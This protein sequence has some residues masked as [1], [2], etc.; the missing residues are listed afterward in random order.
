M[1]FDP[2]ASTSTAKTLAEWA[3]LLD[4]NGKI[5]TIAEMM[6][7][8]N[9]ILD[10]AIWVEGNLPTGHRTTIRTDI[11]A[12]TWRKLNYGVQ[13]TKSLTA[14]VTDTIGMLEAYSEVDKELAD[15]NGN[16]SE[17]RL[18]E[19]RPHIEGMNQALATALFY[20]DTA[21]NP[22]RFLGLAPRY[23][24]LTLGASL[25]GV[26]HLNGGTTGQYN[27]IGAGGSG[28]DTT[29]AYL[30]VW[31]QNTVHMIFPK[32]SQAGLQHRDMGEVTLFDAAGG[33]YQGYRSHYQMKAGLC[34][35]DWR[36]IVRIANIETAGTSNILTVEQMIRAVNQIPTLGM[37]KPVFYV[38]RTLKTQLDIMA[39][40][41]IANSVVRVGIDEQFGKPVTSVL[42][43][44]VKVC[45]SLINTETAVA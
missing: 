32:G 44:P 39:V 6:N 43:I 30:V 9:P 27:V 36:Y 11:P 19:D 35:R 20:G 31:G 15:L 14:Q 16:T 17:F 42:G 8:T 12:P 45:D 40:A 34:V 25:P 5:A 7:Q 13:P 22:E 10:D 18:S 41:K 2:S 26:T 38:N 24:S 4:P 29:S 37:G 21:L 1:A 33:R 28:G 3:K 23:N